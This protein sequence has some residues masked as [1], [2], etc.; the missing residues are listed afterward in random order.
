LLAGYVSAAIRRTNRPVS[1]EMI[2]FHR[3]EQLLK[4]RTIFAAVLRF[5]KVDSFR[6]AAAQ[7]H[8]T[9]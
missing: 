2:R 7:N 5:K 6:V 9:F 1:P 8:N 3:R 4:L